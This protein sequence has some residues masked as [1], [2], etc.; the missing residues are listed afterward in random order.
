MEKE[1]ITEKDF[2]DEL[3]A[4]NASVAKRDASALAQVAWNV[5]AT[6][7]CDYT[8]RTYRLPDDLVK[9]AEVLLK[10]LFIVAIKDM[11]EQ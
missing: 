10:N 3:K 8:D 6:S 9:T 11:A 5:V 4:A 1:E 2:L 7:Y